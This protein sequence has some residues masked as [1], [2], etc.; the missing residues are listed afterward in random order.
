M[1]SAERANWWGDTE[2]ESRSAA[3]WRIGDLTLQIQREPS[4]WRVGWSRPGHVASESGSWSMEPGLGGA[5]PQSL[6]RHVFRKTDRRLRL[7]PALADRSVV[8]SPEMPLFVL[9]GQAA[10]LYVGSPLWIR[11]LVHGSLQPIGELPIRRP[12]DTWFGTSTREGELCYATRSQA[13]LDPDGVPLL[14]RRAVTPVRIRNQAAEP[15]R[16]ERLKLPVPYLSLY[17]TDSARLWTDSVTM[18]RDADSEMASF[19]V[20]GPPKG[21]TAGRRIEPPRQRPEKGALIRAFS[22]LFRFG[23][24]GEDD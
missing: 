23:S 17:E 12:S 2:L 5:E 20:G 6:E 10:T 18:T 4:E 14:P 21:V 9:P 8:T 19:E 7:T 24:E 1:E 15:L 16:I 11:I 13:A 3:T 22:S